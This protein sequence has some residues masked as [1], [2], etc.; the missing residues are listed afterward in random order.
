[1]KKKIIC[2]IEDLSSGGAERQLSGLAVLLKEHGYDVEV[3][4]YYPGDFYLPTLKQAGVKYRYIKEAQSSKSRIQVLYKEVKKSKPDTVIAY[5]DTACIIACLLKV[6]GLKFNLI[7]SER[8]TTQQLT[9]RERIKFF[10]YRFANHIVPNSYTQYEFVKKHFPKLENKM[11][12]ITNFVDTD[13]FVPGNFSINDTE[14]KI[15]TAARINPQKNVINYIRA[16]RLLVDKGYTL[17]IVWYGQPSCS[18]YEKLCK[19]EIQKCRLQNIFKFYPATPNI[20]AEYHHSDLFCLP[21][22]YEGFPNVV[23][24]AMSCGLPIVC[25]D[26]CDNAR[27]IVNK[28]NGFLFNPYSVE[29]IAS[30]I[31]RFIELGVADRKCMGTLSR[32][33]ALG[34]FSKDSFVE[35]YVKLL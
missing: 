27:I 17:R 16:I 19:E 5:L 20:I 22:V 3:W 23:C 6:L 25:S 4:T 26:V 32:K 28:K 33:M 29:D 7:V 35:Q 21:S 18:E 13:K 14:I 1:M 9:R 15:L 24:E 10:M 34:K 2:L 12:C 8:N 31:N 30:V 11:T